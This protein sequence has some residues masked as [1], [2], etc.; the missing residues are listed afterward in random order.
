MSRTDWGSATSNAISPAIGGWLAFAVGSLFLIV[1]SL[2]L[3]RNT[4]LVRLLLVAMPFL[5]KTVRWFGIGT[6]ALV[7]FAILAGLAWLVTRVPAGD[8]LPGLKWLVIGL[9][10]FTVVATIGWAAEK[11]SVRVRDNIK[12]ARSSLQDDLGRDG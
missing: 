8:I 12:L 7:P 9:A 1:G 6:L 5:G 2:M 10:G 4:K 3:Y 11:W